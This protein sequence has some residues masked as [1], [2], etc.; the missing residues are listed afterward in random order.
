[1]SL[2]TMNGETQGTA[3]KTNAYRMMCRHVLINVYRDLVSTEAAY[4]KREAIY[5]FESGMYKPWAILADIEPELA[6]QGF[7]NIMTDGFPNNEE[8]INE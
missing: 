4:Y 6:Y 7:V 1:M 3:C 5:F 2:K 8:E